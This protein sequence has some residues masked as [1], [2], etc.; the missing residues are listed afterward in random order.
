[1]TGKPPAAV[2]LYAAIVIFFLALLAADSVGFVPSY[3]DDINPAGN[4]GKIALSNLPQLGEEQSP[5][6]LPERIAISAI[7]MDLPL[8]NPATKD[9]DALTEVLKAG[10]ARYVDSAR[11]GEKGNMLLFGHSSQLP[12]VRNRMYKAFNNISDLREGDSISVYGG[13]NEYIYSVKSVREGDA[14]KDVIDLSR[15]K[16]A[17]LTLVTCNTFGEKSARWIVEAEFI[18]SLPSYL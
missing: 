17:R 10:P 15:E 18:G 5:A 13:G 1:E 6:A 11:L 14:K 12:I 4:Y 9:I 2:F 8:Q 16:G 3:I 7:G